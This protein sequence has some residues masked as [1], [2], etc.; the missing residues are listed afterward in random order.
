MDE[1]TSFLKPGAMISRTDEKD[2][3]DR[4]GRFSG[5]PENAWQTVG[6]EGLKQAEGRGLTDLE[7]MHACIDDVEKPDAVW[8]YSYTVE[9]NANCSTTVIME[10]APL[11]AV[12]IR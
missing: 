5:M 9:R 12:S 3:S 2:L 11:R 6:L 4:F 10:T 7:E 1:A 8:S